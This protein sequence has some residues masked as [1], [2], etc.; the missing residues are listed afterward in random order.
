MIIEGRGAKIWRV[1][2][3]PKMPDVC[4]SSVVFTK[5]EFYIQ[6]LKNPRY[7]LYVCDITVRVSNQRQSSNLRSQQGKKYQPMKEL[8]YWHYPSDVPDRQ[9]CFGTSVDAY[10]NL[11]I[12]LKA[13]GPGLVII[14]Q[15]AIDCDFAHSSLEGIPHVR[16]ELE[17][18][19]VRQNCSGLHHSWCD[20]FFNI[21][22]VCD[23]PLKIFEAIDNL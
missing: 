18:L 20:L 3:L 16:T 4:L 17:V 11:S 7:W 5:N 19:Q 1:Y 9:E 23:A 15:N 14:K 10:R 8:K 12:N 6:V 13:Q 2:I 21:T 22:V